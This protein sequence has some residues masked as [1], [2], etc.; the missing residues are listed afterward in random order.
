MPIKL[1]DLARELRK[2]NT[3]MMALGREIGIAKLSPAS[4]LDDE[5]AGKLRGALGADAAP[6]VAATNGSAKPA[7]TAAPASVEPGAVIEVPANITVKD[8]GDRLGVSAGDIQKVLM[9]LGVL[10]AVNQRLAGDAISRIASKLGRTVQVM[11]IAPVA[12]ATATAT[13]SDNKAATPAPGATVN[14]VATRKPT[15]ANG[16]GS[17]EK[18]R[19]TT[20]AVRGTTQI[21]MTSRPPVVTIMGHV[22]HGKT[23][24]LDT[25]RK[26]T[27]ADREA[28]GI[29]QHIG[30]YQVDIDGQRITFLDTPGHAA[31]SSMRA[32]G[33]NVTDIVILVVAANDG[34]MPQT[35]EALSHAKAAKVPIIV[36]VN[37]VDHPAANPLKV[38]QQL[39]D[40]GL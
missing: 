4:E 20:Q 2:T 16:V 23:T 21:E 14:G 39:Q 10:A 40:K 1:F 8:L 19:G 32:R 28:G 5:T 12:P 24:L 33:A 25:I 9:N 29:T 35:L 6:P 18:A 3:E 22:D 34:V 15:P 26:T 17:G 7:A 27:V 31:F 30:A 13:V 11:T 38:R 36:A 37:K